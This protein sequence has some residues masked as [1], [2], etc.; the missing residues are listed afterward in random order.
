MITAWFLLVLLKSDKHKAVWAASYFYRMYSLPNPTPEL[1]NL[2]YFMPMI[3]MPM[4]IPVIQGGIKGHDQFI[5][6]FKSGQIPS[7]SPFFTRIGLD[8]NRVTL[9]DKDDARMR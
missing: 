5:G 9:I 3:G 1:N 2:G 6:R 7:H 4:S 8:G